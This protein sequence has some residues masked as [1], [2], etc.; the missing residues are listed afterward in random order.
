MITVWW[1]SLSVG[2]KVLWGITLAAS[3]IFIVQ[4][5][6]TFIGAD[7]DSDIDGGGM[8]GMDGSFDTST[9]TGDATLGDAGMNLLTFRNFVNFFLGF[10][11]SA[12]LL[13]ENIPSIGWRLLVSVLV[14][15]GLVTLVMYLFKWLGSMQ[16]SGNI[17]LA[18]TAVGCQGKVYLTIPAGRSG[19]GKVQITINNSVREYEAMTDGDAIKTGT[20]IRVTEV[21]DGNTVIVEELNSLIV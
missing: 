6:M 1:T 18:K 11:W 8:D 15:L 5:I 2:M 12:I 14:G 9:E 13:E 17:D 10:G 21:L 4:T 19:Q 3:L 7:V 20:A 16:A